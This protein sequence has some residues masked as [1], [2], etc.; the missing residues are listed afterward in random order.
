MHSPMINSSDVLYRF[1]VW[2]VLNLGVDLIYLVLSSDL[3]IETRSSLSY[4]QLR[5]IEILIP[6]H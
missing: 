3:K 5:P 6:Y 1:L 4:P 2:S